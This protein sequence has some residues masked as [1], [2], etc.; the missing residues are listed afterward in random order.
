MNSPC[1]C[2]SSPPDRSGFQGEYISNSTRLLL[3]IS[4]C[5]HTHHPV[6]F[7]LGQVVLCSSWRTTWGSE[8]PGKLSQTFPGLADS[9]TKGRARPPPSKSPA[10]SPTACPCQLQSP[11]IGS[12]AQGCS[13]EV[14]DLFI[15]YTPLTPKDNWS[16]LKNPQT[17]I[18]EMY[19][20]VLCR[21]TM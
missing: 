17:H 18:H 14:S 1:A 8:N 20:E 13:E 3:W 2:P 7:L 15:V 16:H 12:G 9:S 10:S 19:R 4:Q 6:K 5:F 11:T 21:Q